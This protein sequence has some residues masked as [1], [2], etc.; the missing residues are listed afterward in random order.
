[1]KLEKSA[2]RGA[3]MSKPL[4]SNILVVGI[5]LVVIMLG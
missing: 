1:M 4:V 5:R 3:T 2:L